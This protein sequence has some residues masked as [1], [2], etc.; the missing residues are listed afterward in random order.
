MKAVVIDR[1]GGPEVLRLT[2][3]PKPTPQPGQV[4]IQ[5]AFAGINPADYKERDGSVP[6]WAEYWGQR[7]PYVPGRDAA[8]VVVETGADVRLFKAGDRVMTSTDHY[9]G[10]WGSYAEFVR[11]S[12]DN[13]G[14]APASISLAEAATIPVAARTAWQALFADGKGALAAGQTVLIH[15]ASGGVGGF[16]VQFA[17]AKGVKVAATCSTPN[18]AYVKGLGA[19]LVID[20]RTQDIPAEVRAWAP[21]GVDV[22]LD[23]VGG[24]TLPGI[25]D[26]PKAGGRVVQISTSTADDA[27]A[28]IARAAQSRGLTHVCAVC[29]FSGG[30]VE[31]GRIA[32]LIDAGQVKIPPAQVFP[33]EQVG[34]AQALVATQHVRGKVVVK[35]ADLG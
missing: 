14:L 35:V 1:F 2:D 8:G 26:L 7:F 31:L 27:M 15:G 11:V 23:A 5:V 12:E 16:A 29:D 3:M 4:L 34:A 22:V 30:P 33:L 20:Y 25:S 18:V 10:E 28:E 21:G 13:V 6:R 17:K 9:A 24:D 19:D 32:A